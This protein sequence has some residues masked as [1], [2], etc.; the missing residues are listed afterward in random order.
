ML[1]SLA[2]SGLASLLLWGCGLG[3]SAT[4]EKMSLE[5]MDRAHQC[6]RCQEPCYRRYSVQKSPKEYYFECLKKC[7][8]DHEVDEEICSV[9]HP[10]T[11]RGYPQ[12]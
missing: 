9:A 8:T 7:A 4:P 5:E 1:R 10:E 3:G 11:F 2:S 12:E 6:Y